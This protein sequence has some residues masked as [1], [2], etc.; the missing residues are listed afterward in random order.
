MI[1]VLPPHHQSRLRNKHHVEGPQGDLQGLKP[2]HKGHSSLKHVETSLKPTIFT[3]QNGRL[4]TPF[5]T[6][7]GSHGKSNKKVMIF[8]L[9]KNNSNFRQLGPKLW[10]ST[11]VSSF[12]FFL[13]ST[14]FRPQMATIFCCAFV[15]E[16]AESVTSN[17]FIAAFRRVTVRLRRAALDLQLQHENFELRWSKV[18]NRIHFLSHVHLHELLRVIG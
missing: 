17:H 5:Q 16:M 7:D 14:P 6:G 10:I 2:F 12:F 11:A 1:N 4:Q 13:S 18:I 8:F 9:K 15:A 3:Q